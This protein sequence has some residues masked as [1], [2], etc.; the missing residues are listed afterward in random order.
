MTKRATGPFAAVLGHV[1]VCIFPFRYAQGKK[2]LMRRKLSLSDCGG[3]SSLNL[4]GCLRLYSSA[5]L[6]A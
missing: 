6:P 5:H 1:R 3:L 2:F 4:C